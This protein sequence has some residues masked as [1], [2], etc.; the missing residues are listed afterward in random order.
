MSI[1]P[2]KF[3]GGRSRPVI[4][5]FRARRGAWAHVYTRGR[6]SQ[7][8][9]FCRLGRGFW[10]RS[11]AADPQILGKTISLGGDPYTVIG[12]MPPGVETESPLPI[13][14]WTPFQIDPA[15]TE[16]NHYFT[17]A[18]RVRPGITAAMIQARL[19][20]VSEDFLRKFPS[21]GTM[22]PGYTFAVQPMR[23][24]LVR[25]ARPSLL[26][27]AGAVS[28]VLLIA[29]ANVANLLL[30]R[31]P[32]GGARSQSARPSVPTGSESWG[33]FSRRA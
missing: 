10:K 13:D 15:G 25:Q 27:L 3:S 21:V 12:I 26:I 18:A 4:P 28:F 30:V 7:R 6:P 1:R 19:R 17:V 5:A 23:D 8:G 14:V 24:V 9:A 22:L 11:F 33:N 2:V 20:L 32:A 31:P 29:C 16:Q